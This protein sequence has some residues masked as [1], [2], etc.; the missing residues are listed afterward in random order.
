MNYDYPTIDDLSCSAR[1]LYL[2]SINT[3]HKYKN[4]T[5]GL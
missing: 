1:C 2:Y 5:E 4:A 3:N